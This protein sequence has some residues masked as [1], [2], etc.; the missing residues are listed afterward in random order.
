MRL[1]DLFYEPN[2]QYSASVQIGQMSV[3]C[4][5]CN[6]VKFQ[7]ESPGLCY[8]GGKVKL[9]ELLPPPEPLFQ[10]LYGDSPNSRHFLQ[11]T[12]MYNDCF[13]MTSFGGEI[14]NEQNYNPTFKSVP[15]II[16]VHGQ[17]FNLA[18]SLLPHQVQEHKYLQIYF[19]GDSHD[20]LNRRCTSSMQRKEK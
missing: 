5:H 8:A 3:V 1:F 2:I 14:V 10:L 20:E 17:I 16:H 9:P 4:Q 7:K 11:H 19:L 18:G 15:P 12:K 13:Q 6:A